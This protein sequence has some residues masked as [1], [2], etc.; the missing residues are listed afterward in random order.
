[1]NS[2]ALIMV[3][4]VFNGTAA[5]ACNPNNPMDLVAHRDISSIGRSAPSRITRT[6]GRRVGRSS[7]AARI[8]T[9]LCRLIQGG[10]PQ[11]CR[12]NGS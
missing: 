9:R 1:M 11:R 3:L 5:L 6:M 10:V 8:P 12:R 4:A 7:K 2:R